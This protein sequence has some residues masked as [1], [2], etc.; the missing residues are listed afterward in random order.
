MSFKLDDNLSLKNAIE[1]AFDAAN[2][3]MSIDDLIDI[4]AT[5]LI[6]IDDYILITEQNHWTNGYDLG[7]GDGF[8]EGT[9]SGFDEAKHLLG[10]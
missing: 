1:K 10:P 9:E 7:Y 3:E 5:L 6:W 4:K 2:E 8:I